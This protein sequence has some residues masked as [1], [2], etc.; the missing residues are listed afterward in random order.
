MEA[1]YE[2]GE[3]ISVGEQSCGDVALH[4]Q[5]LFGEQGRELTIAQEPAGCLDVAGGASWR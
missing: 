4:T 2:I 5:D 1:E 3:R